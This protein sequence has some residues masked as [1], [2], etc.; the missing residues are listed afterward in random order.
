VKRP[1]SSPGNKS[2]QE[3]QS[4]RNKTDHVLK[5]ACTKYSIYKIEHA[6]NRSCPPLKK[7]SKKIDMPEIHYWVTIYFS[8][9]SMQNS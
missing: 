3:F 7:L 9:D 1:S 2:A 6:P 8:E 4:V 5:R